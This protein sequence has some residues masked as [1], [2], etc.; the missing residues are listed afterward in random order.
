MHAQYLFGNFMTL[1]ITTLRA[2]SF[3]RDFIWNDTDYA[4]A[5]TF[6]HILKSTH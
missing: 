3:F 4:R 1:L 6:V 2:R 5:G